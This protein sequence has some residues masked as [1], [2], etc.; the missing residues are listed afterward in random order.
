MTEGLN[1][2]EEEQFLQA[3]ADLIPLCLVDVAYIA[4]AY[5]SPHPGVFL[6]GADAAKVLGSD[7]KSLEEFEPEDNLQT[8]LE[9]ERAFEAQMSKVTRVQEDVLETVY[10]GDD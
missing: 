6:T 5:T 4:A 2:D 3:N 9:K 8:I 10:L 7:L 1:D